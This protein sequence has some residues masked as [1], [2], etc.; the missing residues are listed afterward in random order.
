MANIKKVMSANNLMPCS[1]FP[2][3]NALMIF[4]RSTSKLFACI[5]FWCQAALLAAPS[6]SMAAKEPLRQVSVQFN[7]M[8]QFE[9]AGP[10]AALE[11]GFYREAGLDVRLSQGG[12]NIDPIAPVAE[13]KTEFGI[14]G[15]SLVVD[16]FRKKPVIALAALMQHSAVGLLARKSAGINSVHDLK[17]KRVAVTFDTADELDAYLKSQSILP[18]DYQRIEH[19]MSVEELDAGKVDAIAVYTSNELFHIQNHVDD[20]ILLSPRSS[21]ID[22][23]GNVLFTNETMVKKNPAIV[24]AFRLATIKGWEYALNHPEEITD[25]ILNRPGF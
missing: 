6:V 13:G 9:F 24:E 19:F 15:S 2:A 10:I 11:K 16:R 21:G 4:S 22:L 18:T 23:F 12:P 17:G 1:G 3:K 25:I 20:Y 7:W 8:Y 14:A 5:L